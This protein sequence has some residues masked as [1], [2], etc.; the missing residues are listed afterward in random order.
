MREGEG[1]EGKYDV[2]EEEGDREAGEE[3]REQVTLVVSGCVVAWR[4]SLRDGHPLPYQKLK[5]S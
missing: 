2:E 3:Q 1:D 5:W 4:S